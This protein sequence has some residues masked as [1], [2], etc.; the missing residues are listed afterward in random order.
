MAAWY[1]TIA[2]VHIPFL[3]VKLIT[4]VQT[5]SLTSHGYFVTVS[6]IFGAVFW[7]YIG[8]SKRKE[9]SVKDK[10]KVLAELR[11]ELTQV[12]EECEKKHSCHEDHQCKIDLMLANCRKKHKKSR[13]QSQV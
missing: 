12:R 1:Y 3:F 13:L 2:A 11:S 10:R 9:A 4:L 5:G 7:S 8:Y 6:L